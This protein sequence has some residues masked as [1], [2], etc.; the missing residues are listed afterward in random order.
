MRW[1]PGDRSNI[2]DRRGSSARMGGAIPLG[3]GGVL[4]LLVLSWFT[5]VDFL[6]LLG[7]GGVP[8]SQVESTGTSGPVASTPE[9]ERTVD[10]VDSV[11]AD[12][13][14][15]WEQMIGGK[16][17]RTKAILFRDATQSGCGFAQ[18]AVGPFYCP[19]DGNVYLDLQFFN[20]LR[21]RFGAPGEFAQAYV[22]AHEVG[23]HVQRLLGTESRVRQM[24]QGNPSQQNELSVRME[25][26]A[27]CYAGVWGH[28]AS[29]S[30]GRVDL[31]PGDIDD[32][33]RAAA[34]IGDDTLQ[35]RAGGRVMP[36]RFT[37]GT[38]EQRVTWFR[39]G[40]DSGDPNA[41]DTFQ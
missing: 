8:Q 10:L 26:Q 40:F 34:A 38:S 12:T 25:L 3:I 4:V 21:S 20:E 39:R 28:A 23:H 17:Q 30:G 9:E 41:C 2:E 13:Q 7:G 14:S 33:L 24:Q 1:T 37:H 16:Y 15:A 35:K 18:A 29:R 5:G 11:M 32:G 36:D 27:D 31:D 19:A 6:S 22:L